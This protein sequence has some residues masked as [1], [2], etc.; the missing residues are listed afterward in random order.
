FKSLFLAVN[1]FV[2][3]KDL[4]PVLYKTRRDLH[5]ASQLKLPVHRIYRKGNKNEWR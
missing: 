4:T 3:N 5:T 2:K 1:L